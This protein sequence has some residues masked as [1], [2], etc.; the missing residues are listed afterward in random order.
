MAVKYVDCYGTEEGNSKCLDKWTG[1]C[2]TCA[3]VNSGG[4]FS[5]DAY[6]C[7]SDASCPRTDLFAKRPAG[8]EKEATVYCGT[9]RT[10]RGKLAGGA[11]SCLDPERATKIGRGTI[12][13]RHVPTIKVMN[14]IASYT[15]SAKSKTLMHVHSA[16]LAAFRASKE[17]AYTHAVAKVKQPKN[18][19]AALKKS[20]ASLTSLINAEEAKKTTWED[21]RLSKCPECS[22][23]VLKTANTM[24]SSSSDNAAK[25]KPAKR[26]RVAGGRAAAMKKYEEDHKAAKQKRAAEKKKREDDKKA[27]KQKRAA[28]KKKREEDKKAAKQKEAKQKAAFRGRGRGRRG[29]GR[30]M[31][32]RGH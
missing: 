17:D 18:T 32:R 2:N 24:L 3:R 28:E 11:N 12:K 8:E 27:A 1:Q 6:I 30:R 21:R 9:P 5:K 22:A 25:K 31:R 7:G 23:A 15:N 16:G 14:G 4:R 29:R 13:K 10:S 20:Q 19:I 26:V